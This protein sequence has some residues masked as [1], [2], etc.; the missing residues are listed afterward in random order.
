MGNKTV[1]VEGFGEKNAHNFM[2]C[3]PG[4]T[5]SHGNIST[6]MIHVNVN[7]D[8]TCQADHTWQVET[9]QDGI[10][11]RRK[12]D[13]FNGFFLMSFLATIQLHPVTQLTKH[14]PRLPEFVG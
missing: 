14:S 2:P 7:Y 8:D 5:S 12:K 13:R 9:R 1:P 10:Y 4:V 3:K 11:R 6:M